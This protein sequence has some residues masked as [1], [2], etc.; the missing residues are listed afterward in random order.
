MEEERKIWAR[1]FTLCLKEK[2]C[3]RSWK[4]SWGTFP[5]GVCKA[6]SNAEWPLQSEGVRRSRG[7][8]TNNYIKHMRQVLLFSVY[9]TPTCS[10]TPDSFYRCAHYIDEKTETYRDKDPGP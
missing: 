4:Q 1:G 10:T 7:D 5:A 6:L 3:S 9:V 2:G 8:Y